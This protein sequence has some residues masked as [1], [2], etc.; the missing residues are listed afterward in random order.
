MCGRFEQHLE[1]QQGWAE[2]LRDWPQSPRYNIKP[3]QAVGTLDAEGFA[4]RQWWLVPSWAR[5]P[6]PKYPTFNARAE[7]L[8]QKPSFRQAW[9]QSQRCIIPASRYFEWALRDGRKQCHAI[10]SCSG[11]PLLLAGLWE[12]WEGPEYTINSCTIVTVPAQPE[13][14]ALHSRMP[15]ILHSSAHADDWLHADPQTVR[16][17]L[18]AAT[19]RLDVNAVSS[20]DPRPPTPPTQPSLLG[21]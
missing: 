18:H 11:Q 16:E 14:A 7:T 1:W 10:G 20:P 4:E 5:G 12:R 3:T 15:L 2:L 9:K 17:Q 6:R 8:H 21:D 19:P 13:M